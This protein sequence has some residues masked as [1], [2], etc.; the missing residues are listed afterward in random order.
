M[1]ELQVLPKNPGELVELLKP[2]PDFVALILAS[3]RPS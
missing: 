1:Q 2:W 3:S